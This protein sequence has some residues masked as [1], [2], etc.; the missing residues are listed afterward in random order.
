MGL[1]SEGLTAGCYFAIGR[2]VR[3]PEPRIWSFVRCGLVLLGLQVQVGLLLQSLLLL[4]L[5]GF[6]HHGR[7]FLFF[8][9]R[10]KAHVTIALGIMPE[11]AKPHPL[12]IRPQG[13]H[14]LI[15]LPVKVDPGI[16]AF[17]TG[18][19]GLVSVPSNGPSH[20]GSDF[21]TL[22][23]GEELA[24]IQAAF[25]WLRGQPELGQ[26]LRPKTATGTLAI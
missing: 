22:S 26:I 8:P 11:Q 3:C 25:D 18:A 21:P 9:G 10:L 4:G 20:G 24:M 23:T 16:P 2:N 15:L 14:L 5:R 19:T 13:N 1:L 17:Y 12:N 7:N 6:R